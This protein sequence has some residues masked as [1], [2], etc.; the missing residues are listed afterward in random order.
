[1]ITATEEERDVVRRV[2]RVAVHV[3]G[4]H[5]KKTESG[6]KEVKKEDTNA[7]T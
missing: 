5:E 3:C 7:V 1:M 4:G 2:F 6:T